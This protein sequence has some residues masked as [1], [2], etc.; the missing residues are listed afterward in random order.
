ME[1]I[2]TK[3]IYGKKVLENMITS[4]CNKKHCNNQVLCKECEELIKYSNM[5]VDSCPNI[6]NKTFPNE[7]IIQC[8]D[9]L[10]RDKIRNVMNFSASRSIY[11]HPIATIK[12]TLSS[13]LSINI[14]FIILGFLSIILGTIGIILPVLPT[15]PFLLLASYFFVKGSPKLDNWFKSTK[16]YQERLKEFDE[17][18]YMTL[19]SKIILSIFSSTMLLI[20]FIKFNIWP[21]RI[22]IIFTDIFKYYF[23]IF[24]IKTKN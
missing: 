9:E 1:V 23:F 8:Y 4:Y 21:L 15:T 12:N 14:I 3:R 5:T 11:H 6:E 19:K 20:A 2:E 17:N 13:V 10:H 18:R 7:C 24:K 16:L 22:F